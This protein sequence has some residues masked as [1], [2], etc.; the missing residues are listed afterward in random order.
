MKTNLLTIGEFS[1][2]TG[3]SIKSLRYYDSI[4]VLNPIYINPD[5][6]YRYYSVEQTRF[7]DIIQLCINLGIPLKDVKNMAIKE[8]HTID[9]S[10]LIEYGKKIAQNKI[11]EL[12]YGLNFLNTLQKEIDR[13]NSYPNNKSKEFYMDE[14][15]YYTI[16]FYEDNIS[17]IY[18][19][20]LDKAF[21]N[22]KNKLFILEFDYGMIIK[23]TSNSIRK[24]I[25]IEINKKYCN[26]ENVIKIPEGTFLCKKTNAFDLNEICNM[27]SDID[28]DEK[29]IVV[30]Y[31]YSYDFSNPFFEIRC[32]LN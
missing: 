27:F 31:E 2:R 10:D 12:Q 7:I 8:D 3:C 4:G 5:N 14:K 25:S 9:Y 15:Y 24:F 6:N 26:I 16:E 19:K 30:S 23:K 22:L 21:K 1:K 20:Y 13:T 17:D 18:Y 28:C 29:T 11:E 32:L